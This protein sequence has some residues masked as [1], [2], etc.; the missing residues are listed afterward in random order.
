LSGDDEQEGQD[1][2]GTLKI[3][4]RPLNVQHNISLYLRR[5]TRAQIKSP[6]ELASLIVN[7]CANVFADHDV[8]ADYQFFDFFER[9]IGR[10]VSTQTKLFRYLNFLALTDPSTVRSCSSFTE[11]ISRSRHR[12]L[13]R[14]GKSA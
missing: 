14:C 10:V 3:N 8:P 6:Y 9:S 4:H 5:A 2:S 13:R 11:I 1:A 7:H 12:K